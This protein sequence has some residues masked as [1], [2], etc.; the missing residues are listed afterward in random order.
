MAFLLTLA[1]KPDEAE[2]TYRKA[3]TL[4]ADLARSSPSTPAAEPRRTEGRGWEASI[5]HRQV[6]RRVGVVPP[7]AET[8]R[9]SCADAPGASKE[10]RRDLAL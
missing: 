10:A 9:R 4:L 6:R 5:Q 7:G 1:G 3:E 8:I 2:A